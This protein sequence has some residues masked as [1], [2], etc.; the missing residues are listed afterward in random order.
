MARASCW[1]VTINNPEE[2]EYLN[3][4]MPPG[5]Y[6]EGQIEKGESGTPHFQGMLKTPQVRMGCV[7]RYF[8]RAHIEPARSEYHLKAYVHKEESRVAAVKSTHALN[9][10]QLQEQVIA[11]WD[12]RR[13]EDYTQLYLRDG[14][15]DDLYLRFADILVKEMI[16]AGACGGIEYVAINPMWRTAWRK[17]G[18][19]IV[20]RGKNVGNIV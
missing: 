1:S 3:V 18:S 7:K 11:A 19:A 13:F 9:V 4:S 5:W 17:F 6:L 20:Y 16:A 15:V 2:R 12:D 14:D 10:F 8:Q